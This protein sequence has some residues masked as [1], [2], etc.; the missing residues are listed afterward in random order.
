MSVNLAKPPLDPVPLNC[1]PDD[2]LRNNKADLFSVGP[3]Y[4][5]TQGRP[6]DMAAL[7]ENASEIIPFPNYFCFRK[8]A[9]D[10]V[11]V[12]LNHLQLISFYPWHGVFSTNRV[13]LC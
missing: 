13:L 10:A 1:F 9:I 11:R 6:F 3:G 5:K 8:S 2:A 12:T 4:Y 7:M